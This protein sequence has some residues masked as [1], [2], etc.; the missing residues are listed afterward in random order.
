MTHMEDKQQML[1]TEHDAEKSS[2]AL[3]ERALQLQSEASFED[4]YVEAQKALELALTTEEQM[5]IAEIYALLG[6]LSH[7]LALYRQSIEYIRKSG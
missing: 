3:F 6:S 1:G 7:E 5:L 4:S 2:R